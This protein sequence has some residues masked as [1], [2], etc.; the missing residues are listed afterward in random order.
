MERS[1]L[2]AISQNEYVLHGSNGA[3]RV[4]FQTENDKP[5]LN[6][7]FGTVKRSF[8]KFDAAPP[9]S[10]EELDKYVGVY[11][12]EEL[13]TTYTFFK[14]EDELYL[15]INRNTP[16]QVY[17]LETDSRMVW[18]GKKMLWIGFGEIKFDVDT[19]TVKGF[20]IGDQRVSDVY[21][22]KTK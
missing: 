17:P 10:L 8:R 14:H 15:K 16:T 2:K 18:N 20:T 13:G 6:I 4:L 3:T 11:E 7:H 1:Y 5:S 19:E 12:S 22:K 9:Q 21:F